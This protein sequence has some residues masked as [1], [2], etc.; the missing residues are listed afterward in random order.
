MRRGVAILV[1]L[2]LCLMTYGSKAAPAVVWIALSDTGGVHA[3]AAEALRAEFERNQP[4]RVEWRIAHLSQFHSAR[5]EPQWLVAVG[6][7]AQRAMQDLF[8][9]DPTP[10]PLLAILVPRLAFERLADPGRVRS[11]LQSAVFLD[12]PPARQM[13]LVRLALPSL[14]SLGILLGPESKAHVPALERAARERGIH[15]VAS[16]VVESGL[17]PA[18]QGLLPQ[19]D[20]LLAVPDPLVFNGQ[21]AANILAATYRRRLPLIGFSPAYARAGALVS[22]HSTPA[23][24]GERGGELLYQAFAGR[25]LPPPQWPRDFV[26]TVNVDVARSLGLPLDE[27]RLAEALHQKEKP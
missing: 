25:A 14:H 8:G 4:G 10:P 7:A 11:G 3:E 21:T 9:D 17:F 5:P 19:V 1:T 20:A 15:L 27:A 26:V 18:L 12:Q 23:Q 22:L 16:Q 2:I 13:A 6:T 24:V